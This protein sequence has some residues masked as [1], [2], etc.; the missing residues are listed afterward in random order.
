MSKT[1]FMGDSHLAGYQ[2]IPGKTGPGS[3]SL[4]ND[5]SFAEQYATLNDCLLYT[6]PSPR[7]S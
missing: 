2:T 7:D 4:Y 5:N 6:S 3:Y 1:L